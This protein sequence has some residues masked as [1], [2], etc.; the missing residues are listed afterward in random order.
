MPDPSDTLVRPVPVL[1]PARS[2]RPSNPAHPACP[3]ARKSASLHLFPTFPRGSPMTRVLA[4][5]AALA[6][7][8]TAHAQPPTP[9]KF[10]E[11]DKVIAGAR[12]HEGLFK[13]HQKEDHVYA[14]LQPFQLDRPYLCSI[15]LARGGMF[16]AGWILNSDEQWVITFKRVGDK[17]HLIR[18]NVRYKSSPGPLARAMETTYTDSVLM[19]LPIK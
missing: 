13:L 7:V 9:P 8:T 6:L 1:P 16:Q 2:R 14:E 12:T 17:V 3:V 10:E 4:C 11:F 15:S 19:A 5:L 18:K